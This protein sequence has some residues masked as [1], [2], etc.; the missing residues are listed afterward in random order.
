M[1]DCPKLYAEMEEKKY[2]Y[3]L[4]ILTHEG[5]FALRDE[6]MY[7]RTHDRSLLILG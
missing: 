6:T 3:I 5:P 1:G 2:I 4:Y 7:N